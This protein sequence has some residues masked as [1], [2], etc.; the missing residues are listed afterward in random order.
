MRLRLQYTDWPRPALAVTDT[1]RPNCPGGGGEGGFHE[2]YGDESG[3][4]AGTHEWP[5]PC[6]TGRRWRL[7][8]VP[9]SI[10]RRWLGWH[11]PEYSAEPPF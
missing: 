6:W 2:D 10:A 1:P 8:P 5:C 9:R 7:T 3:E 4:Y 11:A